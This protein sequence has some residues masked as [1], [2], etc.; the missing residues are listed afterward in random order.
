L[1]EGVAQMLKAERVKGGLLMRLLEDD[2][3]RL[4]LEGTP[5]AQRKVKNRRIYL[6]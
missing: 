4:V 2:E 3:A 5:A 1:T 6:T